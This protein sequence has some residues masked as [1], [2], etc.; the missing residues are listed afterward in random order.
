MSDMPKRIYVLEDDAGN[1]M[2]IPEDISKEEAFDKITQGYDVTIHT[3]VL[4][5]PRIV[6]RKD[7]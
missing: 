1:T 7:E 2:N 3:Y 5:P 4:Q 6:K